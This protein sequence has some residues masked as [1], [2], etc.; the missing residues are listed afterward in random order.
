MK[1]IEMCNNNNNSD[2]PHSQ[3][4]L[5]L[6]DG[7]ARISDEMNSAPVTEWNGGSDNGTHD[8]H[9]RMRRTSTTF[10]VGFL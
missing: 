4:R 6:H 9:V 3:L 2:F 8:A 5:S 10:P 1:K 7:F